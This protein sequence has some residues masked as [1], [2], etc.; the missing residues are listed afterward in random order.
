MAERD[1]SKRARVVEQL[2]MY[3][4]HLTR[5]LLRAGSTDIVATYARRSNPETATYVCE[6]GRHSVKCSSMAEP[7]SN[8]T[9]RLAPTPRRGPPSALH[10]ETPS[11]HRAMPVMSERA[12]HTSRAGLFTDVRLTTVP[13]YK[14]T[15][16]SGAPD[17]KMLAEIDGTRTG[18]QCCQ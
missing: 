1:A 10:D 11:A 8:R 5:Q 15:I 16:R 13:E 7:S 9:M 4:H 3:E 18:G 2:A 17:V 6:K 12:R 14:P